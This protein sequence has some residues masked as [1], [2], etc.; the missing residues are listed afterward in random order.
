[1]KVDPLAALTESQKEVLRLVGRG[2]QGGEI[3][4]RL[5]ISE[6]SVTDRVERAR[7]KLGGVPRMVAARLLAEAEAD[8]PVDQLGPPPIPFG[9]TQA[10]DFLHFSPTADVGGVEEERLRFGL[11]PRRSI[12]ALGPLQRTAIILVSL[13]AMLAAA[14]LIKPSADGFG[15]ISNSLAPLFGR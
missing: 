6:S 9:V 12:D 5:G 2:L 15:W 11:P 3:A 13:I 14:V 10:A 8:E 1:M 4:T 7:R